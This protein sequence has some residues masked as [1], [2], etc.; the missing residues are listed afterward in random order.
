MLSRSAGNGNISIHGTCCTE[1]CSGVEINA[2]GIL[3]GVTSGEAQAAIFD[4]GASQ[5]K[6]LGRES[7]VML[8]RSA[9]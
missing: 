1:R 9:R 7:M 5:E 2:G 4:V 8:V 6:R 3:S